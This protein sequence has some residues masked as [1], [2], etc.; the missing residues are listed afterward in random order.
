MMLLHITNMLKINEKILKLLDH[1]K[2][3]FLVTYG[4]FFTFH[5]TQWL[6]ILLSKK[7]INVF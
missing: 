4:L 2:L 5:I 6:V 7:Q 1:V 3:P